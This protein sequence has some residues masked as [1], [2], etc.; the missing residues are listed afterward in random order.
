[1]HRGNEIPLVKGN[2]LMKV[3]LLEMTSKRLGVT[4]V[5]NEKDEL[6]GVITDGDLR[7]ALER[8]NNLL[9]KTAQEIMTRN[10]RNIVKDALAAQAL[11]MMEEFTITSLFILEENGSQ[12]P[13]GIIHMHDLLRA[14]IV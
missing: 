10:P 1:M 2:T 13:L 7:R 5:V 8:Y 4:G 3:A 11:Q 6:I 12:R 9:N 14:G